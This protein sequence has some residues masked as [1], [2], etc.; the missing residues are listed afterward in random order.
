MGGACSQ[1]NSINEEPDT[2][3]KIR[4]DHVNEQL[5]QLSKEIEKMHDSKTLPC[6]CEKT[7]EQSNLLRFKVEILINMLAIEEK[8]LETVN[9][10]LEAL[11]WVLLSQ[12][13]SQNS[14]NKLLTGADNSKT[15]KNPQLNL[16]SNFLAE[17]DLTGA[18]KRMEL[19]FE[20]FREGIIHCFADDDG[21][22]IPSLSREEFIRQVY[23]VTEHISKIDAQV[24]F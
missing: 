10:R 16:S 17:C 4:H 24:I 22:V 13:V 8:K 18:M 5:Q 2:Y 14:L 7:V 6:C 23:S 3:W 11:K 15:D 9:K 20:K 12:G 1:P 19:D 21:R